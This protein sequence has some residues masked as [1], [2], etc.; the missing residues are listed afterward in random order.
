MHPLL[1][2]PDPT[3]MFEFRPPAMGRIFTVVNNAVAE[4][5]A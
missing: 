3:K 1:V 4:S 5:Q 2:R